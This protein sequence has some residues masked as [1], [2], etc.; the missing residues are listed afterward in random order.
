LIATLSLPGLLGVLGCDAS[1]VPP[2]PP[3]LSDSTA[4]GLR[5]DAG[6]AG[7][8]RPATSR[9]QSPSANARANDVASGTRGGARV[10]KLILSR[11]ADSDH[12]F[13]A[14]VL[15]REVGKGRAA[16]R[17]VKPEPDESGSSG[18]LI[19]A[20]R[21]ANPGDALIVE[22]NDD[23]AFLESLDDAGAR[24]VAILALDRPF[25]ARGNKVHPWITYESL[26]GAGQQIVQTLLEAAR[27]FGY[28]TKDRIVFLDNRT[29]HR[30]RAERIAAL[31]D[32]LRT[33]GRSFETVS[34]EGDGTAASRAL[35][36]AL[37]TGPTVA[38]VVAEEDIGVFAAQRKSVNHQDQKRPEFLF[39][40]FLS[41][42]IRTPGDRRNL[43][44]FCDLN[45]DEFGVKTF[46]TAQ[47]LMD[48]K[49]VA[50]KTV[51]PV[52]V[53]NASTI[54]VPTISQPPDA[55]RSP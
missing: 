27:L 12:L 11:P 4:S 43:T 5:P 3:E 50:E 7:N 10:V 38:V 47:Q 15:R 34:F 54:V 8:I 24:G 21:S 2:P 51:V 39:G 33:A 31:T 35:E 17:F 16:F 9:N 45:V 53:R 14:Q 40:G 36:K 42:D 44:A 13:L 18:R 23:P 20:I 49:S 26:G 6:L 28:T 29:P 41:Y 52:H 22:V 37:S 1:F 19:E 48:G 55:S 25:P 30:Y 32:A 46:E